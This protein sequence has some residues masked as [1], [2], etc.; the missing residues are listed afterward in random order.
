MSVYDNPGNSRTEKFCG[1]GSALSGLFSE[2]KLRKM[3]IAL[4]SPSERE[5]KRERER[6][7]WLSYMKPSSFAD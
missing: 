5:K 2:V 6:G 4:V 3:A 7:R 1:I